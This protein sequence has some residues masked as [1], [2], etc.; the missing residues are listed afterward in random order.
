MIQAA[1]TD[2]DIR[3]IVQALVRRAKTGDII[4]A[5]ELLDRLLGKASQKIDMDL[6]TDEQQVERARTAWLVASASR[7][8]SYCWAQ[9]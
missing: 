9:S 1:V 5:R 3:E 2:V 8:W 6:H 7:C 4:A